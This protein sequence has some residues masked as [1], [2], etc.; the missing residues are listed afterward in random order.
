MEVC[1]ISSEMLDN[2]PEH[3][4]TVAMDVIKKEPEVDPLAIQWSDD[5]YTAEKKPLSEDGNLLD[6]HVTGIKTECVDHSYDL[7]SDIKA[8]ETAVPT[9]F[10]RTKCKVEEELCDLDTVKDELKLEV[11]TEENEILTDRTL[12]S[13]VMDEIKIEPKVDPLYHDNT[14]ETEE[15]KT[16]SEDENFSHLEVT[17]MKTEFLGHSC[18]IKT[19]IKVDDTPVPGSFPEVKS[20]VDD[21]FHL[22]GVQQEQKV[23]VSSEE[24]EVLTESFL[25]QPRLIRGHR[26]WFSEDCIRRVHQH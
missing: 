10:L 16:L 6:L 25:G 19:E 18:D 8:E 21:L 9:D 3:Q 20:E 15:N 2:G 22:D 17:G 14:H 4:L 11:T 23:E 13:V 12:F 1:T 7:T 5:T 26:E 24:D